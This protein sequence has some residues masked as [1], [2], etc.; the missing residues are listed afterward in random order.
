[1][2][3][4]DINVGLNLEATP[5]SLRK[6]HAETKKAAEVTFKHGY[7]NQGMTPPGG[8][9]VAFATASSGGS[10]TVRSVNALISTFIGVICGVI[11]LFFIGIEGL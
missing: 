2:Q 10:A 1:M 5:E 8:K 7:Q 6:L 4:I 11:C 9:N 3:D